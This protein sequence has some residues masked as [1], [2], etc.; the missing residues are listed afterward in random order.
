[1]LD[2]KDDEYNSLW[3]ELQW[4]S[5]KFERVMKCFRK[6]AGINE[7][8]DR[9]HLIDLL[10]DIGKSCYT[11]RGGIKSL[12]ERGDL[13]SIMSG[14]D[15]INGSQFMC[16]AALMDNSTPH[17]TSSPAGML[18]LQ[19]IYLYYDNN[20]KGYWDSNDWYNLMTDIQYPAE[21]REKLVPYPLS[22]NQK[23]KF[24][25][26]KKL[27]ETRRL[28]GT[29]QLLRVSF[30]GKK[31]KCIYNRNE[32]NISNINIEKPNVE[33]SMNTHRSS[34]FCDD[35]N[36]KSKEVNNNILNE[37]LTKTI[38]SVANP[39]YSGINNNQVSYIPVIPPVPIFPVNP[40]NTPVRFSGSYVPHPVI[41]QNRL[42]YSISTPS[43]ISLGSPVPVSGI[44][45]S[46]ISPVI[47][48][49]VYQVRPMG[50]IHN[51]NV[52][53]RRHTQMM[54]P[55]QNIKNMQPLQTLGQSLQN[56]GRSLQPIGQTLGKSVQSMGQSLISM[57]PKVLPVQSNVNTSRIYRE[58]KVVKT[59]LNSDISP[60]GYRHEVLEPVMENSELNEMN[61]TS[62]QHTLMPNIHSTYSNDHYP[63]SIDVFKYS[64]LQ[65][66]KDQQE[67]IDNKDS[68]IK[69]GVANLSSEISA[70]NKDQKSSLNK[71]QAK[72]ITISFTFL[73]Q[74]VYENITTD[75]NITET[76]IKK[77]NEMFVMDPNEV[78]S[79]GNLI[80]IKTMDQ[81][82]LTFALD[83]IL[84][85]EIMNA[86]DSSTKLDSGI[87]V[88]EIQEKIQ[89]LIKLYHR[90]YRIMYEDFKGQYKK[91]INSNSILSE[92][93]NDIDEIYSYIPYVV[94]EVWN[95]I[96]KSI[97]DYQIDSIETIKD[98]CVVYYHY[99]VDMN[100]KTNSIVKYHSI[101]DMIDIVKK[102]YI[103]AMKMLSLNKYTKDKIKS[104]LLS[105]PKTANSTYMNNYTSKV[106]GQISTSYRNENFK[107]NSSVYP[108]PTATSSPIR[109]KQDDLFSN[110]SINIENKSRKLLQ[111]HYSAPSIV[112]C[113][114]EANSNFNGSNNENNEANIY[115]NSQQGYSSNIPYKQ[116]TSYNKLPISSASANSSNEDLLI[117]RTPMA[118]VERK[119]RVPSKLQ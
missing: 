76:I 92:Y 119:S 113:L 29:S 10:L 87:S 118:R 90:I 82:M 50:Q 19:L 97:A 117:D 79:F 111:E 63:M 70:A 114:V 74:L 48:Q 108:L 30:E 49:N 40:E 3:A 64:N 32:E 15:Y 52:Q 4:P 26:L 42:N 103:L 60:R 53:D 83:C 27:V 94:K 12:T 33:I 20:S 66:M 6:Y 91:R 13:C 5:D 99:I 115:I 23:I 8:L 18:R 46:M 110:A 93:K 55:V 11:I 105:T 116:Y 102:R 36:I 77:H 78:K 22:D 9:K 89:K 39:L 43:G 17:S 73:E 101:D 84:S 16:L 67:L 57:I 80:I 112:P 69:D 107:I 81:F 96:Q 68:K 51:V 54:H 75:M 100:G 7:G 28:R 85:H 62:L 21:N 44:P 34:T 106:D 72:Q 58:K 61:L 98:I 24:S 47:S 37:S 109:L 25:S 35:G 2:I 56:I 41:Y 14:G 45:V 65:V 86:E 31:K 88:D 1:M 95:I 59:S 71:I 38:S 104:G